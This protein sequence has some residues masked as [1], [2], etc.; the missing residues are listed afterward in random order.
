[1]TLLVDGVLLMAAV[2]LWIRSCSEG[3]DVWTLFLRGLVAVDLAV[4]LFG[5]SQLLIELLLLAGALALPSLTRI[6]R[7]G[8]TLP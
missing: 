1:M 8:R 6:E 3:D 5:N 2:V 7:S 4:V